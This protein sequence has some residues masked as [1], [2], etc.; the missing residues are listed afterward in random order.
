VAVVAT[1]RSAALATYPEGGVLVA[2]SGSYN[3]YTVDADCSQIGAKL[4]QLNLSGKGALGLKTRSVRLS[5]MADN[6]MAQDV[7]VGGEFGPGTA[8]RWPYVDI[9]DPS[10]VVEWVTLDIVRPSVNSI[11]K[12]VVLPIAGIETP[13]NDWTTI[14]LSQAKLRWRYGWTE[15]SN[16]YYFKN[17]KDAMMFA[18][19]WSS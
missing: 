15:K 12:P 9:M 5:S 14:P 1:S 7:S 17:S 11:G 16:V 4:W 10:P 3:L 2:G 19:R 8:G 13:T 18:L 6:Y